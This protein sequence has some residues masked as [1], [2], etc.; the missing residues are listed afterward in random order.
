MQPIRIENTEI[1]DKRGMSGPKAGHQ[2]KDKDGRQR[3]K[4]K[5][6]RQRNKDGNDTSGRQTMLKEVRQDGDHSQ[7]KVRGTEAE[8]EDRKPV[9]LRVRVNSILRPQSRQDK[10]HRGREG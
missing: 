4:D 3:D 5:N 7:D 6:V 8:K 1:R 9:P 10:R 2:G